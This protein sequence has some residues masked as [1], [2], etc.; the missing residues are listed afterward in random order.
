MESQILH[1]PSDSESARQRILGRVRNLYQ[2][3]NKPIYQAS[4][5]ILHYS[6]CDKVCDGRNKANC[7]VL[8][9]RVNGYKLTF[10]IYCSQASTKI[11]GLYS[12]MDHIRAH[13]SHIHTDVLGVNRHWR[14]WRH[15]LERVVSD[16]WLH[17]FSILRAH[18]R[19]LENESD[20]YDTSDNGQL[21]CRH[22]NVAYT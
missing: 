8:D 20:C 22:K 2:R 12:C 11:F 6:A 18:I 19:Q 17:R 16:H 7:L 13:C 4:L 1:P 9:E 5:R 15:R 14:L 10:A 21:L 3:F